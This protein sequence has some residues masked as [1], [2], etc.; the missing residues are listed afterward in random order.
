VQRGGLHAALL[1][2]TQQ[3][4][5]VTVE[6]HIQTEMLLPEIPAGH[7]MLGDHDGVT[8]ADFHLIPP[9]E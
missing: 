7:F 5:P 6:Q 4:K 3:H 9:C 8:V 2:V 1:R